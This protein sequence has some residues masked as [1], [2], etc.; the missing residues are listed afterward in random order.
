MSSASFFRQKIHLLY[1]NGTFV[2]S[3]IAELDGNEK[4]NTELSSS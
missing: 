1:V 3:N 4:I 2:L